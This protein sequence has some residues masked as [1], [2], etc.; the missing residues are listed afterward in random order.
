MLRL[1]SLALLSLTAACAV[2]RAPQNPVDAPAHPRATQ[3]VDGAFHPSSAYDLVVDADPVAAREASWT[4]QPA[5]RE[6]FPLN[7][8]LIDA[9]PTA[10]R[11]LPVTR[12]EHDAGGQPLP[13]V[14]PDPTTTRR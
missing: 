2:P 13:V 1:A 3:V 12:R 10:I 9:E 7:D 5:A 11:S 6:A 8:S 14:D 4:I